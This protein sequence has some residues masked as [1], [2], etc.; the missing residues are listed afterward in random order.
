MRIRT[1][2][3]STIIDKQFRFFVPLDIRRSMGLL[4]G[5][6]IEWFVTEQ[7]QVAFRKAKGKKRFR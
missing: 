1:P 3:K 2:R 5:G 4:G 6:K 7:G